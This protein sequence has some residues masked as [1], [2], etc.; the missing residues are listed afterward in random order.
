MA[1]VYSYIRFSSKKQEQGDS[2]RRQTAMGEAWLKRHPEHVLDTTLRLRDL[3]VSAFR[4]KNLDPAKGDLG[5]F[6]QLAREGKVEKGSILLLENLDRFSRLAPRKAYQEFCELV[7]LGVAVQTLEPEQL[8]NEKNIDDMAS[9]LTIIIKMQLSFDESQKKSGRLREVWSEKRRKAIATHVPMTHT[10]PSWLALDEKVDKF[11]VKPGATEALEYIFKRACEGIGELRLL[12]ELNERFKT[13]GRA[14]YWTTNMVASILKDR[15]VCGEMTPFRRGIKPGAPI[16]DYYPRV[17]SDS[18]FY[19]AKAA[20]NA[21]KVATGPNSKFVNLF[22]GL[23]VFSDGLQGQI[24][25]SVWTSESGKHM[26]RRFVSAGHRERIKGACPNPVR[27]D[28]C[29]RVG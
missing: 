5:K 29:T 19:Q 22:S 3:G 1:T 10:C 28:Y 17:I 23:V 24:Q 9:T 26:C 14:K 8:I 27:L 18:L 13:L 16:V 20:R 7:G 2:V 15:M 21:R 6:I 12:P 4:G 11:V 25:T